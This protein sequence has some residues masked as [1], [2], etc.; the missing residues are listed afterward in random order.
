VNPLLHAFLST[1]WDA[2]RTKDVGRQMIYCNHN[3]T[4]LG[5]IVRRVSGEPIDSFARRR[6]FEPLGMHR[7]GYRLD[8]RQRAGLVHRALDVPLG[9]P[10]ATGFPGTEGPLWETFDGGMGGV[11]TS[12]PDLAIFEQM[13]LNGGVYN[14][15]RV[16]SRA[17][18]AAMTR[19]QIPGV[20][21]EFAGDP[22]TAALSRKC[23]RNTAR[24]SLPACQR[25]PP[26]SCRRTN[27]L[28]AKCISNRGF[29][30]QAG[31]RQLLHRDMGHRWRTGLHLRIHKL[32]L[33][34]AWVIQT[35]APMVLFSIGRTPA[36][37]RRGAPGSLLALLGWRSSSRISVLRWIAEIDLAGAEISALANMP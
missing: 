18:V 26:Q 28:P 7:S 8:D 31:V 10:D 3:Y 32:T 1:T 5:E 21:T 30:D 19:N 15:A 24:V 27:D 4:L 16:L 2:P 35:K 9:A 29:F 13:F 20:P 22:D 33:P 23:S 34:R 37:W 25:Q 12:A 14:G 17:A 6:L 36:D 11:K